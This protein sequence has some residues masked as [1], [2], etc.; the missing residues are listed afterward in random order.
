MDERRTVFNQA[1][2]DGRTSRAETIKAWFR[3]FLEEEAVR[4]CGG[5][6][7]N[8]NWNHNKS[9]RRSGNPNRMSHREICDSHRRFGS[10]AFTCERHCWMF[11][12]DVYTQFNNRT[13]MFSK[14]NRNRS[15]PEQ[16]DKRVDDDL[17]TK[18]AEALWRKLSDLRSSVTANGDQN[19][20]IQNKGINQFVD[21]RLDVNNQLYNFQDKS[22][23]QCTDSQVKV[24]NQQPKPSIQ[25][26]SFVSQF[27]T[28]NRESNPQIQPI[29]SVPKC[30][31]IDANL[32][33]SNTYIQTN[34]NGPQVRQLA[35]ETNRYKLQS[36]RRSPHVNHL[37]RQI[38]FK[39][40]ARLGQ[41]SLK[42]IGLTTRAISKHQASLLKNA[43]S[44]LRPLKFKQ[45]NRNQLR[46]HY[47]YSNR[48]TTVL[49]SQKFHSASPRSTTGNLINNQQSRSLVFSQF[50]DS[51]IE[52]KSPSLVFSQG[53]GSQIEAPAVNQFKKCGS[54]VASQSTVQFK[55][56]TPKYPVQSYDSR[57]KFLNLA[58]QWIISMIQ[59]WLIQLFAFIKLRLLSKSFRQIVGP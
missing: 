46:S 11:D 10:K 21:Q 16:T 49:Y 32:R 44:Q 37:S 58:H 28:M 4:D 47:S 9:D 19:H 39:P 23:G 22:V 8:I 7:Q 13:R 27:K 57:I 17:V 42:Q 54:K 36:E 18:L 3:E 34:S 31:S 40:A 52:S 15:Y 5:S 48:Y 14:P 35:L 50:F 24:E 25:S 1:S 55:C 30:T 26:S 2:N 6:V 51:Q 56:L 12:K 33:V 20:S 38:P 45:F 53:F 41:Y 43:S 29:S 59:K